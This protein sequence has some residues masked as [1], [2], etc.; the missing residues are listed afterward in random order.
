MPAVCPLVKL[1]RLNPTAP[2]YALG[3][4]KENERHFR[5]IRDAVD[6]PLF[7]Y[8]LPVCVHTKLDPTMLV[9]LGKDGVLQGVKEYLVIA[10]SVYLDRK[11]TRLNSSH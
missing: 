3:G 9:R 2:F 6:L 10:S 1:T 7:A 8:D 5:V 11:S 4:P